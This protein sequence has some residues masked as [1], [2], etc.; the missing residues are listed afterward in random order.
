[1][2]AHRRFLWSALVAGACLPPLGCAPD[3]PASHTAPPPA[4]SATAQPDQAAAALGLSTSST[5]AERWDVVCMQGK[6]IGYS[7]TVRMAVQID[8]QAAVRTESQTHLALARLGQPVRQQ[9]EISSLDTTDGRL[10]RCSTQVHAGDEQPT[11]TTAEVDGGTLKLALRVGQLAQSLEL[12]W[13]AEMGGYFAVEHSLRERPM[14]PG[15]RRT[16][17]CLLPIFN[18]IGAVELE[19]KDY[20]ST[21]LLTAS[22]QLLRIETATTVPGAPAPL[23]TTYWVDRQGEVLKTHTAAASQE[24]FRATRELALEQADAAELDLITSLMAPLDRPIPHP[25]QTRRV[26][27]RVTMQGDDPAE[28]IVDGGTQQVR[29]LGP[30]QCEVTVSALRPRE[31]LPTTGEH[32]APTDADLQPNSLIQSD[33]A[34]VIALAAQAAGD[35]DNPVELAV[36]LERFV[37]GQIAKKDLSQSLAS[38]AEVAES[39]QGDCTEHAM[40]LAALARARGIPARVAVGLVYLPSQE[41]AYHMWTELYLDG[42]WRPLD[43]TLGQGGI[44]GA[45]LK[46]AHT[47]LAGAGPYTAFLPVMQVMGRVKIELVEAE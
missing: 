12:P 27:Y 32:D 1:M 30:Q 37:H 33:D 18:Q 45:H 28:F 36:R 25:H 5:P 6:R 41:M 22:E 15:Q 4:T 14:Q 21:P 8:G 24:T 35:L 23:R 13:S 31:Q 17:R 44:G 3:E 11:V 39:L 20:E 43:A 46:L 2:L 42:H 47:N 9:V 16:L 10:L 38:A 40:L 29:R 7:H 34:G 26:R 19:A